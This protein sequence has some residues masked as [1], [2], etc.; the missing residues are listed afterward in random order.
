MK[1]LLLLI[2][3]FGAILAVPV[4]VSGQSI[5]LTMENAADAPVQLDS[6]V[7]DKTFGFRSLD[8]RNASKS[9]LNFC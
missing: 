1:R 9:L 3:S 6:I 2:I 7:A 5:V 8:A 4:T